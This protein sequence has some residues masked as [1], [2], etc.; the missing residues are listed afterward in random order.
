MNKVILIGNLGQDPETRYTQSGAP[1]TNMS[2]ATGR[3]WTDKTTGETK[4][5]TSWHRLTAFARTAEIAAQYL[6]KG[7]KIAIEGELDYGSYEKDGVTHYTTQIIVRHLEMLSSKGEGGNT[8][9][10]PP[11]PDDSFD[12]DIP[13]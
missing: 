12:E 5:K 11:P 9:R 6:K 1:V 2:L 13:F 10:E 4:E 8:K 3:K 7:S